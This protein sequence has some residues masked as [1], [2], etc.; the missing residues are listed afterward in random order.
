MSSPTRA[1]SA[2]WHNEVREVIWHNSK[3]LTEVCSNVEVE[4]QSERLSGELFALITSISGDEGRLDIS[5]DGVWRG[6]FEKAFFDVR[7]FNPCAKSNFGTLPSMYRKHEM[8]KKKR[9]YEQRIREVEHS[10]FT[11]LVLSC[12]GGMGRI[13]TTF[14]K[15]L[16]SMIS[17]KKDIIS[18]N[19]VLWCRF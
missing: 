8:E 6:R 17:E 14:Y 13:A 12:T 5:A 4:P 9:C 7:V 18:Y 2:I 15:R 10:A 19:Q 11:S 3:L 1:F 16:A